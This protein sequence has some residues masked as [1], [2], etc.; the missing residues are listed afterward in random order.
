[1][2]EDND[3]TGADGGVSDAANAP[4]QRKTRTSDDAGGIDISDALNAP[5]RAKQGGAVTSLHPYEAMLRQQMHKAVAGRDVTAIKFVL[6]EAE[7]HKVIKPPPS[8]AT[9]GVM[10]IPKNL[11]EDIERQIFDDESYSDQEKSSVVPI[12]LLLLRV[13][14][15]ER[16]KRCFNGGR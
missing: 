12:M 13:I 6:E 8:A 4:R 1:M 11:P 9:G 2:S 14:D 10:T 15:F 16:L 5:V 3:Q 7:K